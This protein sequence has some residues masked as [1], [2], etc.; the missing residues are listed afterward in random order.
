MVIAFRKGLVAPLA[1]LLGRQV[2]EPL[3]ERGD[4]D[5]GDAGHGLVVRRHRISI[6]RHPRGWCS[7][8]WSVP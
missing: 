7:K 3:G 2:L 6:A 4:E 5:A 8:S 1:N